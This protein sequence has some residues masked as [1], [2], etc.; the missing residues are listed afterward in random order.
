MGGTRIKG[1][2][3]KQR[4]FPHP[5]PPTLSLRKLNVQLGSDTN[6]LQQF[7]A[8]ITSLEGLTLVVDVIGCELCETYFLYAAV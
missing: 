1:T 4:F 6:D 3:F 2:Y 5:F 8:D 7:L